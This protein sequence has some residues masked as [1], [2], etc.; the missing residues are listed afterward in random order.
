ME[1]GKDTQDVVGVIVLCGSK[2][3]LVRGVG[4]KWSFPKGRRREME[5]AYQGA[6]REAREE[7]GIDLSGISPDITIQ[8]RYGTYF[9]FNLWRAPQ[10][11]EPST[12]EEILEVS[13]R[14][15]QSMRDEQKNADL[16]FYFKLKKQE[17]LNFGLV[18]A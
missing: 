1:L 14:S 6:L 7:A 2:I 16:K 18:R 8:L 13:W 10:L 12:P 17:N 11:N 5:T 9:L 4:G 3:L 15:F